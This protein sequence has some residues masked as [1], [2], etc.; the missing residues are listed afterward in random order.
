MVYHT[1]LK[2]KAQS[3][4]HCADKKQYFKFF[5]LF[6]CH[7]GGCGQSLVGV[8]T[9]LVGSVGV[10]L[11]VGARDADVG[12]VNPGQEDYVLAVDVGR[13]FIC[14][15]VEVEAGLGAVG[16]GDG[17]ALGVGL[18]KV[19]L[20]VLALDFLVPWARGLLPLQNSMLLI[21]STSA[22][23]E[24]SYTGRIQNATNT[25]SLTNLLP[26]DLF[27]VR[28]LLVSWKE[29]MQEVRVEPPRIATARA[30]AM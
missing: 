30:T 6:C 26:T 2:K 7:V 23:A 9:L 24:I 27:Q 21:T 20:A 19:D 1:N 25:S 28:S 17:I 14:L 29:P 3:G 8:E 10:H 12:V 16:I 22:R 13:P 5:W 15:G 11:T 18:D 4:K